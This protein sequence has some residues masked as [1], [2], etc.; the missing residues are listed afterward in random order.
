MSIK[1]NGKRSKGKGKEGDDCEAAPQPWGMW[2]F[3]ALCIT[4][5]RS[6]GPG[7]PWGWP[8]C[9]HLPLS[10]LNLFPATICLLDFKGLS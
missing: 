6:R 8:S 4:L 2:P 10:I 7:P 5:A 9:G 3:A 1:N